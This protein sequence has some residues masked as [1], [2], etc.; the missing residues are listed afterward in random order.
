MTSLV[1]AAVKPETFDPHL[2]ARVIILFFVSSHIH[3]V[4]DVID[5]DG[6]LCNVS[7]E[8]NLPLALLGVLEHQLL[9]CYR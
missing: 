7:G 3:H 1:S 9:V 4:D 8:D 6:G 2:G 5:G